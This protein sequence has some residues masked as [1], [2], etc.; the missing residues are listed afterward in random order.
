MPGEDTPEHRH[1]Q[2]A[3]RFGVE[4]EGVWPVV[5][6]DPAPMRRADFLPRPA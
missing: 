4:G 3:F 5:E 6:R 1:T 2:N